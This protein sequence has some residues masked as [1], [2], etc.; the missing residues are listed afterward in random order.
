MPRLIRSLLCKRIITDRET[1]DVTY[2][3]CVERLVPKKIPAP[4]PTMY[5]ATL[6]KPSDDG[7][8]PKLRVSIQGPSAKK[9]FRHEF[10]PIAIKPEHKSHRI[11]INIQGAPITEYGDHHIR[12]EVRTEQ[13]SRWTRL[14]DIPLEIIE[15]PQDGEEH[16]DQ[17]G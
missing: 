15:A 17:Q 8:Q 11:N 12:I 1:N 10:P 3:D 9:P 7:D 13:A 16:A 2:V 14:A 5:L 6:W 4:L